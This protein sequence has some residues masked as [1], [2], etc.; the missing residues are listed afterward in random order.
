MAHNVASR[1]REIGIRMAFGAGKARIQ[2]MV[3]REAVW[4]LALGAVVGVGGAFWLMRFAESL[5]YGVKADDVLVFTAATGLI[6]MIGV[7]AAFIPAR[8]AAEVDPMTCLR[9]E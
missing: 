5:L 3:I 1:T 7:V 2:G 4:I 8:R 6:G 9:Y